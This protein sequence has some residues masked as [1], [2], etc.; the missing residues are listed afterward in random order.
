MIAGRFAMARAA[1]RALTLAVPLAALALVGCSRESL[2]PAAER[3][4]Q[5]FQSQCTTC[6]NADPSAPGPVGPAIKGSS[7]AL[8]E[9]KVLH[10]TYP[11][12]YRPKRPTAIMPALPAVAGDLD[13]LAA[14]LH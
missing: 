10:Q 3:G 5:V 14:F 1:A 8:L 7:R 6:H 12:G 4:R 9:A 13:A 2:S 11:P